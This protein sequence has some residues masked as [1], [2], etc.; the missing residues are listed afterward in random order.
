V[1]SKLIKALK[2]LLNGKLPGVL[3]QVVF[4]DLIP[5][6]RGR[7]WLWF[8][9]LLYRD[10]RIG[11][12]IKCWGRVLIQKSPDSSIVFGDK[13]RIGSDFVRSGIALYSKCKIQA[14]NRSRIVLG[15]GVALLGTSITCRTTSIE[16]GDG[17]MIAPNA[18]IVDSD[19]HAPWPPENRTYNMGY[20]RDRS[21]KIGPNVWIGLNCIILK[22]VTIGENSIIGAGSVV[23]RDIPSNVL[24]A[25][26]PAKVVKSLP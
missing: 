22:G 8:Y 2:M 7:Y 3:Y 14:F 15:R 20:E 25:G 26:N 23:T 24:A 21:V 17:T 1:I 13:M 10:L 6:L 18:V 9:R 4:L 19:F 16:I 12:K 5:E 11:R